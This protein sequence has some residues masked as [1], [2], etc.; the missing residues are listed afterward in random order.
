MMNVG[1]SSLVGGFFA[2]QSV[3]RTF[4]MGKEGDVISL[5]KAVHQN[6]IDADVKNHIRDLV[7]AYRQMPSPTTLIELQTL[8]AEVGIE[9]S[10]S[11]SS[12]SS[13]LPL[14]VPV[15]AVS[16]QDT[17]F[18]YQS[19]GIGRTR[20]QFSFAHTT[21]TTART[22]AQVVSQPSID[23]A[24]AQEAL[25]TEIA[26][27]G[28]PSYKEGS[29]VEAVEPITEIISSETLSSAVSTPY[30]PP[31]MIIEP[32]SGFTHHVDDEP[33]VPQPIRV[34]QPV[35]DYAERI[36]EI[37]HLVNEKVGNPVN[38]IDSNNTLGKEYMNALLDAMKKVNGGQ[39]QEVADA[40][41]RLENAC[42]Q[43]MGIDSVPIMTPGSTGFT[44]DQHSEVHT[45][46][47]NEVEIPAA[48][49]ETPAEEKVQIGYS[50]EVNPVRITVVKD[51]PL[52]SV[53]E[54]LPSDSQEKKQTDSDETH[55]ITP[56]H[57][58]AEEKQVQDSRRFEQKAQTEAHEVQEALQISQMDPLMTP[59]ITAGLSQ[60]LSE[61]SLFKS[62]GIFGTG[63]SG[64]DH[65][66][67]T[68]LRSLT[69]A[70][71]IAGRFEGATPKMRQSIGD[72]MNGWR[73]E[74]GIVHEVGETFE[75]Y[76][77]RV[78]FVILNK[79]KK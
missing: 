28:V 33:E 38:L 9:I 45:P 4:D 35:T 75:H 24:K 58:V 47:F 66:L 42:T 10:A 59:Q 6:P 49:K 69:M 46:V 39:P 18:L 63:P 72:Y 74:E 30:V 70:T 52:V 65:A 11:V 12:V 36:K 50:E 37:K 71:V 26:V 51:E 57:S 29:E 1:D 13:A 19:K 25:Q 27:I 7:F 22:V 78:I 68:K 61:W 77:R 2:L 60:L 79:K 76:L 53:F 40:M 17:N 34:S 56:L 48:V 41:I 5:L 23:L 15:K 64:K 3:Q 21:P 44:K 32:V 62:S 43:V 31:H 54:T 55:T 16:V 8:F 73:Y 14:S 20:P 67:Y